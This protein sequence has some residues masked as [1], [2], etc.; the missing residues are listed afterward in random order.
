[1]SHALLAAITDDMEIK[2][3]LFPSPGANPRTGGKPKATYH[4]ALCVLLFEQHDD[5]QEPFS[6]VKTS[7]Q[8]QTWS[9]KIKNRLKR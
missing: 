4:W 1:L 3:G 2:Q 5:Y 9:N 6:R 7:K 8:R